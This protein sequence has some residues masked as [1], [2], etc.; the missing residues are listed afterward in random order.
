MRDARRGRFRPLVSG[1]SRCFSIE[2]AAAALLCLAATTVRGIEEIRTEED[3]ADLLL[4]ET[5]E[6]RTETKTEERAWAVLPQLGYGPDSGPVVGAKFTHRDAFG[7]GA[8]FDLDG[9][10]AALN[11]QAS[12]SVQVAQPHLLD[13]RFL[14]MFRIKGRYDPQREFFGLGNNDFGPDPLSTHQFEDVFGVLTVGWRPVPHVALNAGMTLRYVNIR[15]GDREK[16]DCHGVDPCPFTTEAFPDMPGVEGHWVNPFSLSFVWIDRDD[17]VR[18]TRGP[19]VIFKIAHTNKALASDFE[20][21][22][23]VADVGYLFPLIGE[24]VILGVRGD[25]AWVEGPSRAT[26]FWELAELGG[27]ET[28]PGYYPRRFAGKGRLLLNTEVRALLVEFDFF[29]LWRVK[30]DGVLAG[31]GGR[32]FLER[33]EARDDF[34]MPDE[35]VEHIESDLRYS[36]GGGLRIALASALV[37]RVDVGFSDE[38]KG[39]VYL[40]FG[41][42]F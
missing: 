12:L 23:F 9:V 8:T 24:R 34:A 5:K 30:I 32:V 42:P 36:Y 28:L 29:N 13:D 38:E 16:D 11:Q 39:L 15:D 7:S 40:E 33:E 1:D 19:R 21:T 41:H 26:P 35:V 17:I 27:T 31:A 4:E 6:E 25:G 37:A 2:A 3:I 20:F 18:P 22:R 10:Y 14:A